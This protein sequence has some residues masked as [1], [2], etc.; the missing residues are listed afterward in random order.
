M[1]KEVWSPQRSVLADATSSFEQ[2]LS[3]MHVKLSNWHCK[4]HGQMEAQLESSKKAILMFDQ[5]EEKRL[6]SE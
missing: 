5:I 6:L 2:K 1:V 3:Q 4:N